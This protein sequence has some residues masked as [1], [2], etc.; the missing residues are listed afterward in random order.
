MFVLYDGNNC[1]LFANAFETDFCRRSKTCVLCRSKVHCNWLCSTTR[2]Y[3]KLITWKWLPVNGRPLRQKTLKSGDLIRCNRLCLW[4][5]V[6]RIMGHYWKSSYKIGGLHVP[7][8]GDYSYSVFLLFQS[9]PFLFK[10]GLWNEMYLMS[11]FA[12][13]PLVNLLVAH[14]YQEGKFVTYG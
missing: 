7:Y 9:S 3:H 8:N 6:P 12:I 4:R 2:F 13:P 11:Q 1:K 14:T 10:F 5:S